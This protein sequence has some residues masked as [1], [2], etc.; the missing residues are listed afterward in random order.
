[1]TEARKRWIRK[2]ARFKDIFD[3]EKRVPL[4]SYVVYE[5]ERVFIE[6]ALEAGLDGGQREQ[7]ERELAG[8]M[9]LVYGVALCSGQAAL[10]MALKLAGEK[11]YGSSTGIVTP[12]GLGRGGCLHGKRVFC[13]DLTTADMVNPIVFEGGVSA[14][15][16]C[17]EE[18]GWCMDPEVLELAFGKYPDAGIVVMNHAYGFPGQALR[19]REICHEHGA[20][21]IECAGEALGAEYRVGEDA[22]GEPAGRR[23]VVE[24]SGRPAGLDGGNRS[25]VT[26]ECATG[27][28]QTGAGKFAG[29]L[30]DEDEPGIWV[31][32]GTLGDYCVLSFGRDKMLGRPGGMLFTGDYYSA[33]KARYWASGARAGVLWNQHEELGYSCLMDELTA[34]AL[35]GQLLHVDEMIA[36]KKRIYERYLERLEEDMTC[37]IPVGEGTRPS[38]CVTAMTC[39]SNIEFTETRDDRSYTYESV[40]GTAAPMEIWE[41]L[42]AFNIESRPVYKPMS[43]QPVFYNQEH[44]TLDGPW[45]MYEHFRN[46]VF[47][48]RCDMARRY[49]ERGLCLPSGAGMSEDEQERVLEVVCA[50]YNGGDGG[51]SG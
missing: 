23:G 41:A 50:C 47:W 24:E 35:R 32:A 11:I 43:M 15:I 12:D 33:E 36:G 39:E 38:Y 20:L 30:D 19:I 8:Y 10:H 16:D 25:G 17:A 46:D 14:F 22:P 21:L 34:A 5:E 45:R 13:S 18:S 31:K 44:F 9:G 2:Q 48:A 40:H 26:A 4:C 3:R 7:L 6:Q 29:S 27:G 37:L 51:L 28:C 42:E 1:M 49:Y